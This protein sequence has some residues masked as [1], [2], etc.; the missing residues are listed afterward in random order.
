MNGQAAM[1]KLT[2]FLAFVKDELLDEAAEES[3]R[4][5]KELDFPLL[6]MFAHLS[7]E[8]LIEMSKKSIGE[9]ADSMADGTYMEKQL[10]K[11][12][13]WEEDKLEGGIS[14]EQIQPTD[15]VMMYAAQKK[16]M[17]KFIPRFTR[18]P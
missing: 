4:V 9:F 18:D 15:L 3:L 7:D 8:T 16:A 6:K 5:S 17:H 11:L 10:V 14:K 13:K 2:K 1:S 12:K